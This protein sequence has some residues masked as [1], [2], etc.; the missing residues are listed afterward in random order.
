MPP[1]ALADRMHARL[2]AADPR[3][4]GARRPGLEA[5]DVLPG[6]PELGGVLDGDHP[7]A[8]GD[9]G[10]QRV[11]EG[12]LPRARAAGHEDVEPAVHRPR[13]ER[14]HARRT[15]RLQIDDAHHEAAD[16]EARPIDGERRHDGVD[17]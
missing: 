7:L 1:D 3:P 8:R 5:D 13:Q 10:G 11:E 14:R 15:H 12:R 9:L 16:G 17:P 4:L 2:L 6:Q